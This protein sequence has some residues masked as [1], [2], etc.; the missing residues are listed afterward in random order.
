MMI[1]VAKRLAPGI[2]TLAVAGSSLGLTAGSAFASTTTTTTTPH[3]L[4][5]KAGSTCSKSE[6]N[7]TITVGSTTFVCKQITVYRWQKKS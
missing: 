3:S 5:V 1:S 6:R 2:L 4:P 7:K